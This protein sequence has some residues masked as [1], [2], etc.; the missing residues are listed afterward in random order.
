VGLHR[1][2]AGLALAVLGSLASISA[3]AEAQKQQVPPGFT[4]SRA[5][6]VHDFDYFRGAWDTVQHRLIGEPGSPDAKWHDFPGRLCMNPYLDGHVTVDELYF[7]TLKRGGL[8]LKRQWSIYWVSSETG[9]LDPVP[10]VG[11]FEG[12]RG[13]FYA[14]DQI[15]DRPVKVRYLWVLKDN[16]HARWEQA[17]SYDDVTWQTNW[18]ADFTRADPAR[19]CSEGRPIR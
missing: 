11:G 19:M 3:S 17:L 12:N 15:K 16:D 5:G 13:E 9:R 7:P 8:T 2:C 1:V 10:T 4:K 6:S 14:E 18:A